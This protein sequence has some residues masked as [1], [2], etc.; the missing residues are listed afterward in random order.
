MASFSVVDTTVKIDA[1]REKALADYA[2]TVRDYEDK[3]KRLK[4]CT[5]SI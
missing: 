1:R 5:P 2:Q 4:E 3:E